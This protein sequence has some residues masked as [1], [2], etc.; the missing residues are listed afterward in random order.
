MTN[1][2][3]LAAGI[4]ADARRLRARGEFAPDD[5]NWGIVYDNV[6]KHM[7]DDVARIAAENGVLIVDTL[8]RPARRLIQVAPGDWRRIEGIIVAVN[9]VD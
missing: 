5:Y 6:P 9:F 2:H 3:E 4:I 7:R 1:A 8:G